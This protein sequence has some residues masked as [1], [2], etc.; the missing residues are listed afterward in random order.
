MKISVKKVLEI[1]GLE[2]ME[3]AFS[4]IVPACCSEGCQVEPDGHCEHGHESVLLAEG[5]I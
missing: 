1:E 3:L 2:L 5:L 4:S